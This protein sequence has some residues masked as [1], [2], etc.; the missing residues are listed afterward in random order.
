MTIDDLREHVL[1]TG[2]RC[3]S[4]ACSASVATRTLIAALDV[5]EAAE[6]YRNADAP[7][8]DVELDAFDAAIQGSAR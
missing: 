3:T 5:V 2:C 8:P 4:E 1:T 7:F 6:R